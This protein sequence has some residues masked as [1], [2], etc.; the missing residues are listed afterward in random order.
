MYVVTIHPGETAT[1]ALTDTY[2]T[3]S[4]VVNKTITGPA[5]G[6]QGQ[7]VISVSCVEAGVTTALPDFVIHAAMSP[8]TQ[9]RTYPDILAGSPCTVTETVQRRHR[10]PACRDRG[11]PANCDDLAGRD[12][13][14]EPDR[15][16]Q[17]HHGFVH[18]DQDHK[19]PCLRPPGAGHYRRQLRRQ[20]SPGFRDHAGF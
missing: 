10:R 4:L 8:G 7:V 2:E 6:L 5:A 12:R 20:P 19:W 14:R 16:L 3:G 9:S 1:A 11:K 18:G 15:H 17:P 13:H